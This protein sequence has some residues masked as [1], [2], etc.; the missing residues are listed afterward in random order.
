M[1]EPTGET[2]EVTTLSDILKKIPVDRLPR[3][4]KETEATFV[5]TAEVLRAVVAESDGELTFEQV[6][7]WGTF[8]NPLTWVDD[9]SLSVSF[10]FKVEAPGEED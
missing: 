2:Y 5:A 6:L 8:A 1:S 4:F 7:E 9:G 3:F 10:R